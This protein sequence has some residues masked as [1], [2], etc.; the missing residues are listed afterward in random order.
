MCEVPFKYHIMDRCLRIFLVSSFR[1]H[2]AKSLSMV[3]S[4]LKGSAEIKL[5]EDIGVINA[6]FSAF[7]K[8]YFDEYRLIHVTSPRF[9]LITDIWFAHLLSTV[10]ISISKPSTGYEKRRVYNDMRF[11][12]AWTSKSP[13]NFPFLIRRSVR[14]IL[15]ILIFLWTLF[16]L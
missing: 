1:I 13:T 15:S 7:T 3:R 2:S 6:D 5:P 11:T 8:P 16:E 12:E 9:I 10:T 4:I 14:K